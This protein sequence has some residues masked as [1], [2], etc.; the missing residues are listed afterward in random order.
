MVKQSPGHVQMTDAQA[1]FF[2]YN[3]RKEEAER[4]R[5]FLGGHGTSKPRWAR[6]PSGTRPGTSGNAHSQ[7]AAVPPTGA[8]RA[9]GSCSD[10]VATCRADDCGGVGGPRW[11]A[12]AR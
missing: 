5:V 9:H 7:A 12:V 11:T 8:G 6:V 3:V 1:K 4:V 2:E 10:A